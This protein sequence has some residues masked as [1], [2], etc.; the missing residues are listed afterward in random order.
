MLS[1]GSGFQTRTI[2]LLPFSSRTV[3][4]TLFMVVIGVFGLSLAQSGSTGQK[5]ERTIKRPPWRN[6]PIRI[7]KIKLRGMPVSDQ[8]F[9]EDDDWLKS[10]TLS[11]KNTSGRIIKYIEIDLIFPRPQDSLGERI[12]RDHLMYGQYPLLP[13]EA[14]SPSS[15]APVMPNDSVSIT[16]SDYE[17]MMEFLK[18]TNYGASI[19]DLELEI[20]MV[21]FNDDTKWSGGRLYRRDP[22]NPDGWIPI[23]KQ[24]NKV[25][26]RDHSI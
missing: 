8:K 15:E 21:I 26:D 13:G 6:E 18:Q 19:R 12:S 20:S 1:L 7:E 3:L 5:R 16:L 9:L 4:V 22:N 23:P 14:V 24:Q 25:P 10:L 2:A 17:G 11:V